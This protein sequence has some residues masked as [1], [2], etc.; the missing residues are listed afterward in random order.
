[1]R[2]VNVFVITLS[3]AALL[4]GCAQ[5]SP[6]AISEPSFGATVVRDFG[7]VSFW[8]GPPANLAVLLGTEDS[9]EENCLNPES[10]FAS[11]SHSRFVFTPSGQIP[12]GTI[13]REA[14]VDVVSLS[15]DPTD[16][17]QMVGAPLVATGRV[18]ASQIISQLFGPGSGPGEFVFHV[19]ARGIVDLTSGGQARLFAQLQAVLKPDGTA[20]IQRI[21]VALTPL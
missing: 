4:T 15:T 13:S 9:I 14:H 19:T 7:L 1:M 3:S 21:H 8:G 5:S 20:V 12:S 16:V 2:V 6:T 11:P 17:C 10:V 18:Q